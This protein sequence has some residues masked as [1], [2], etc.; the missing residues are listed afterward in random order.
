VQTTTNASAHNAR[1]EKLTVCGETGRKEPIMHGGRTTELPAP[2]RLG[3][4]LNG[5]EKPLVSLYFPVRFLHLHLHLHWFGMRI[6][7]R[8][9]ITE[10]SLPH[11]G[12]YGKGKD[13]KA[14]DLMD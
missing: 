14:S 13:V 12:T 10:Q 4:N 8:T 1:L 6:A 5:S 9:V 7:K 2:L 11:P 3:V